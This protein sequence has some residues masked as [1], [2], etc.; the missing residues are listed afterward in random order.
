MLC[1]AFV[2]W[3][4]FVASLIFLIKFTITDKEKR[5][6]ERLRMP[7]VTLQRTNS[8]AG[9]ELM[10]FVRNFQHIEFP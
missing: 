7:K 9:I 6:K 4:Y 8:L 3:L 2:V 1:V 10:L 5:Q